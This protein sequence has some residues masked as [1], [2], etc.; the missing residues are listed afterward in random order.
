M[1]HFWLKVENWWWLKLGGGS[2][3]HI[4]KL[5]VSKEIA[6]SRYLPA[7]KLEDFAYL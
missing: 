1:S 6:T 5:F 4:K 2:F 7:F 3:H